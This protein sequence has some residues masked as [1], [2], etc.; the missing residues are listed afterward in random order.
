MSKEENNYT[1]EEKEILKRYPNFFEPLDDEEKQLIDDINNDV[2][3]TLELSENEK[4]K[5]SKAVE[6][7]IKQKE[8]KPV[9]L[10]LSDYIIDNLKNQASNYGMNY[11][12]YIN[13]F[14]YQLASGKLK[15]EVVKCY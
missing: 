3:T 11:Q 13:F 9:S 4:I 8:N 14:L 5:Y 15:I 2:Y 7:T 12:S 10:R 1:E 6:N